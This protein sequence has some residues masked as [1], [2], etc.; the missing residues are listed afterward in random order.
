MQIDDKKFSIRPRLS[1]ES[2]K[3]LNKYFITVNTFNR[4]EY[5]IDREKCLLVYNQLIFSLRKNNFE[6]LVF[7]FMPDHLH[8][9]L[10]AQSLDCHLEKFMKH[11]KQISGFYFK[12]KYNQKL[13]ATSYYDHVLRKDE[14]IGKIAYYILNNPVRRGLVDY[15]HDYK[16]WGSTIYKKEDF[17]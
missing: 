6:A 14:Y 12:K 9:L 8:L 16:Y 3:G 5:F 17:Y 1:E 4:M 13:W 2:Y 11:F 10:E 7:L 15:W